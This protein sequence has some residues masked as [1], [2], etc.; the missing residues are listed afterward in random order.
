VGLFC[1]ERA[2]IL[3]RDD[4]L[5]TSAAS[6]DDALIGALSAWAGCSFTLTFNRK[7][8]RLKD[9]RLA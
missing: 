1:P 9:S 5:K 4:R 8:A 2:R 7:A 3:R 6:F